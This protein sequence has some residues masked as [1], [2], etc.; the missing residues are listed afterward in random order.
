MFD[1]DRKNELGEI[2]KVLFD[3][4]ERLHAEVDK[5]L[6]RLDQEDLRIMQII[7]ADQLNYPIYDHIEG[8]L[9]GAPT[10][11]SIH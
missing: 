7:Y 3:I 4:Y 2:S 10:G 1:S 9:D 11:E 6:M 8:L 5:E